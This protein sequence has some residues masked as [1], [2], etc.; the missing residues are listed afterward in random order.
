MDVVS[1]RLASLARVR[2]W[3]QLTPHTSISSI[4]IFLSIYW[5]YIYAQYQ[6]VNF[7]LNLHPPKRKKETLHIA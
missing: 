1:G 7:L 2:V 6:I 4:K 3:I 5:A